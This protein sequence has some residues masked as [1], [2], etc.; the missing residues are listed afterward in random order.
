MAVR[1]GKHTVLLE[2]T[3]SITNYAASGSK[4]EAQGPL[5]DSFDVI[6]TDSMFGE[7]S[8]EKAE[9]TLQKTTVEKVL[10]KA[11]YEK[12]DMDFIFAGDLLN[13][14]VGSAYGLRDLGIPFVGLYGACSTMAESLAVSSIFVES[15]AADKCTAA[16]SSHFCSAERQFRFPL[17]YGGQ[18]TPT[19]QWTATASG[20]VIVENTDKAPY[21]R[22]VTFGTIEDLGVT[23]ANN[24]G[25][26]MAP[27]AAATIKRF[28]RI[29]K[30]APTT[31]TGYLQAIWAR[32]AQSFYMSF[33]KKRVLRLR[34]STTTAG[35][36]STIWIRRTYTPALRVAG[37]RRRFYA[38][39]SCPLWQREN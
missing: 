31:T 14:C 29:Q 37:A 25:A 13:Q 10:E 34:T 23:D 24:M 28:L 19:A 7:D 33:C 27:A 2:K 16:T 6:N 21:V 35:L 8:W 12:S 39:Q 22:A 38:A 18:R 11:D 26:A 4:K 32:S 9:S 5:A 36:C 17:A 30:P 1:Q 20:A 3:V 15:G